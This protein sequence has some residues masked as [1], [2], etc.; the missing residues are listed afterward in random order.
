MIQ[1]SI[2]GVLSIL[3]VIGSYSGYN[4]YLSV[5]G[6]PEITSAENAKEPA[7]TDYITIEI[8]SRGKVAGYLSFRA[9]VLLKDPAAINMASYHITDVIHRK[10]S[11]LAPLIAIPLANQ[12]A[13]QLQSLLLPALKTR[14]GPANVS[15]LKIIDL[16]YDQRIQGDGNTQ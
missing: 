12:A 16:A 7:K 13:D 4:Y 15:A 10:L 2:A 5:A 1:I 3:A 14:M 6:Q 8:F 9:L 11:I